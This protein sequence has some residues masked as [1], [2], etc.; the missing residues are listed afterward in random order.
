MYQVILLIIDLQYLIRIMKI[1]NYSI[2][3][4]KM[5]VKSNFALNWSSGPGLRKD[6]SYF[7]RLRT[8][9]RFM[10]PYINMNCF[11]NC[12]IRMNPGNM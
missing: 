8:V 11:I 3:S 6:E 4:V 1:L 2:I 7:L 5:T 10:H 12:L 9:D